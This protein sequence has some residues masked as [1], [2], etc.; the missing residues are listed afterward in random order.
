MS[1]LATRIETQVGRP[2]ARRDLRDH[3]DQGDKPVPPAHALYHDRSGLHASEG[4]LPGCLEPARDQ[5][6]PRV[7]FD[8]YRMGP[9]TW[10]RA[11]F[12]LDR[13]IRAEDL[14]AGRES[15]EAYVAFVHYVER[16]Y[17]ASSRPAQDHFREAGE[18]SEEGT[19]A[20]HQHRGWG[21][22]RSPECVPP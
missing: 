10:A 15:V 9:G 4:S 8:L 13:H 6:P 19:Y 20:E 21:V 16:I 12:R 17:E 18:P 11:N 22:K 3:P 7:E 14:T 5:Q 1:A 2:L